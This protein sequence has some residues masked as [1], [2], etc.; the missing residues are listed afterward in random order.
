MRGREIST[1]SSAEEMLLAFDR[2]DMFQLLSLWY[3]RIGNCIKYL[4]E[5]I[6]EDDFAFFSSIMV[7]WCLYC[8]WNV[9]L[10]NA[11]TIVCIFLYDGV[12]STWQGTLPLLSV[13]FNASHLKQSVEKLGILNEMWAHLWGWIHKYLERKRRRTVELFRML[14]TKE[15][16]NS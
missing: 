1:R 3:R 10:F 2:H 9:F 16:I 12:M 14:L 6:A 15:S 4:C 7:S 13:Y 5:G 11:R 8:F